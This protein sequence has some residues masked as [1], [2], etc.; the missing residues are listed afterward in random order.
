MVDVCSKDESGKKFVHRDYDPDY[1]P[2][3]PPGA[4]RGD[5]RKQEFC[6]ICHCPRYFYVDVG[7]NCVQCGQDFLFSAKEQKYWYESLKFHFDSVAIRCPKC[8]RRQR[9]EK[10]L[11][12]QIEVAKKA[13]RK[14]PCDPSMLLSLAMA[15]VR[16]HQKTGGG[17]L[18]EA[19][20]SCRQ[21]IKKWPG[22]YEAL[23]WEGLCH[24]E[25]ERPAKA[26]NLFERFIAKARKKGKYRKLVS[27]AEANLRT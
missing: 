12:V 17:N 24:Q 15:I 10:A 16:C 6:R 1:K 9:S 25:A 2:P 26:A 14:D 23:F 27:E 11:H 13:L 5:I 7:K 19:I 18:D 22:A 3:L 4:V 8:R 20:S 21:A